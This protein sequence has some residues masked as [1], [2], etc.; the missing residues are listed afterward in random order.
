MDG[1]DRTDLA[2]FLR[3]RRAALQPGDVG[4]PSGTRRRTEGL[5]RE[6]VAVLADMSIDYYAR[7]EQGRGP[8]PSVQVLSSIAQALRLDLDERDHLFRLAGQ[9]PPSRSR[10]SD[11]VSPALLR[12]LD[13]LDD[14]PAQVVS[15]LAD[16]L[17]QNRM[18]VALFGDQL[19]FTGLERS[20]YYRW[21]MGD[22]DERATCAPGQEARTSATRASNLRA[23]IARNG[24]DDRSRA[25]VSALLEGSAEFREVWARHEV[26]HH[27][28]ELK[29]IMHPQLGLLE[30]FCQRL[31]YDNHAQALLVFT[32]APGSE[33]AEKLELLQVIGTQSFSTD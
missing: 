8:Q 26:N 11:H 7:L 18:A 25:L 12:V 30:V 5:R 27:Y 31:S 10:R 32:A 1:V 15:D 24:E 6:E 19:R 16:V 4:L 13:R 14:T 3:R 33:T 22:P 9:S 23:A 28:N 21:F 29:Q 20:R 2:E 17:A